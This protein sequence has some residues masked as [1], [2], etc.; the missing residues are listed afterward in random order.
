MPC[1]AST[2]RHEWSCWLTGT[3]LVLL[4]VVLV[5]VDE[6]AQRISG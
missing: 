2:T 5:E 1:S 3:L 4:A 6:L